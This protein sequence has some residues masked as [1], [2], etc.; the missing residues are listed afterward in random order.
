MASIEQALQRLYQ[1]PLA[2]FLAERKRL[3]SELRAAGDETGGAQIFS[4]CAARGID[5]A[6][7][8]VQGVITERGR[9]AASM[10]VCAGGAWTHLFCR[11]LGITVPQAWGLG[12][13]A[14]T[15][16]AKRLLE[17]QAWSPRI[18]M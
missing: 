1:A 5:R 13:V 7:G 15:A 6:A 16:P 10:L 9:V 12:T 4:H 14:R 2:D 8:R 18:A 3:A 11:S 17:G